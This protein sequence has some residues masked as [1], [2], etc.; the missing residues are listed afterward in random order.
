MA[1]LGRTD[2]RTAWP[3]RAGTG[4]G[5][6]HR[7]FRHPPAT[8]AHAADDDRQIKKLGKKA[9]NVEREALTSRRLAPF[10]RPE[11]GRVAVNVVTVTGM[12]MSAVEA[13]A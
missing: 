10:D 2:V 6:H 8:P 1:D 7:S 4:Y 12:E 11:R 3:T 13:V 5:C 9:D